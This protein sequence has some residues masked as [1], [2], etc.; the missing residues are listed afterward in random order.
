MRGEM[1]GVWATAATVLLLVVQAVVA[2]ACW[3]EARRWEAEARVATER[4]LA[5]WRDGTVIPARREVEPASDDPDEFAPGLGDGPLPSEATDWLL[6]WEE[7]A[8]RARW[9]GFLR[10]RLREGRSLHESLADAELQVA[11]GATITTD[12]DERMW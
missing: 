10:R 1:T 7:G 9:E 8:A 4:L 3:R 5:A 6:Q 12:D 11:R 2:I